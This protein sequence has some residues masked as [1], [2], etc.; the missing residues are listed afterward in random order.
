MLIDI[1]TQD[2]RTVA[3]DFALWA[4]DPLANIDV[5]SGKSY[6]EFG[7]ELPTD[8]VA[9]LKGYGAEVL[10]YRHK[11]TVVTVVEY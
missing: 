9:Q 1:L 7:G 10:V 4:Y 2:D 3:I 11:G 5:H 8:V 6:A